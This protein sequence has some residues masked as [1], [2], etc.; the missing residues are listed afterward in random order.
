MD[1]SDMKTFAPPTTRNKNT[2]ENDEIDD[3]LTKL[4]FIKI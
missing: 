2:E 4:F 3:L 1:C